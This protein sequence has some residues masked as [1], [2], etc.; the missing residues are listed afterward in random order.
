VLPVVRHRLPG[1]L[2]WWNPLSWPASGW[3]AAA[4]WLALIVGAVAARLVWR[5]VAEARRLRVEQ[6]Q[7]YVMI[8]FEPDPGTPFVMLLVIAN[9]GATAA[10]DV[11]FKFEPP[12][13]TS[14]DDTERPLRE[15]ALLTR[16][17]PTLPPGRRVQTV[18][19]FMI[20]RNSRKE[21]LRLPDTFTAT[22]SFLDSSGKLHQHQ[23]LL[24]LGFYWDL[25][26]SGSKNI[27][28]VAVG[29]EELS[30]VLRQIDQ[31]L[32]MRRPPSSGSSR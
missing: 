10:F 23:Y 2:D 17:I 15:T 3:S 14:L 1:V 18:F 26:L 20:N 4:A 29:L 27:H 25:E 11:Q 31:H 28:H 13:A 24:D 9:V 32:A 19:D 7:P 12:L 5:Q 8:D 22:I 6:A 21:A 16:G 30:K